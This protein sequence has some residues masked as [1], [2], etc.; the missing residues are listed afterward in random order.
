[1][2]LRRLPVLRTPT[3][4]LQIL[5]LLGKGQAEE[6]EQHLG[7]LLPGQGPSPGAR[8]HR[9]R[10]GDLELLW[11]R[12]TEFCTYTFIAEAGTEPLFSQK[13]FANVDQSW[14]RAMPGQVLRASHVVFVD[15]LPG[16]KPP[17]SMFAED[18]LVSCDLAGGAARMWSDFRLHPEG[19]GRLLVVDKDLQGIEATQLLRRLLELGNYR[20]M[21][22]LGLPVAQSGMLQLELL[23][24]RL[25]DLTASVADAQAEPRA[26]LDELTSLSA[27]IARLAAETQ[28]RMSAS[29]AYG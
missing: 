11:E 1:M 20:K 24:A 23:E 16:D 25:V 6:A 14:L 7:A 4:V 18:S 13:P 17:T 28:F 29:A 27:E 8:F 2:H 10:L 12:H 5:V 21:A 26:L 3:H 15:E 19:S 9:C 22:L